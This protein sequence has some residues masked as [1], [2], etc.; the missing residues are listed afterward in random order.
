MHERELDHH[1]LCHVR[2]KDFDLISFPLQGSLRL[3]LVRTRMVLHRLCKD[4]SNVNFFVFD[5][6]DS[7]Q[8]S[9]RLDFAR[10]RTVFHR[11]LWDGSNINFFGFGLKNSPKRSLRLDLA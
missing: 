3:D 8:G 2:L 10:T 9:L 11:L 5:L 1:R 4:G 6:K 7:P